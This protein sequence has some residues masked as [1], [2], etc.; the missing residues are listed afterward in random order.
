[1]TKCGKCG[2]QLGFLE[3]HDILLAYRTALNKGL[4][5]EYRGKKLC[6]SCQRELLDSKGIEYRRPFAGKLNAHGEIKGESCAS[7][8]KK[9]GFLRSPNNN[10]EPIYEAYPEYKGKRICD[11]CAIR[12]NAA[13]QE[14]VKNGTIK[15]CYEC[16]YCEEIIHDC[17]GVDDLGCYIDESYSTYKCRKFSLNPATNHLIAQ[18]CSSYIT[19]KEYQEKCISGEIEKAKKAL[20]KPI[21]WECGYCKAVNKGNF[22]FNCGSPRKKQK[23]LP[24]SVETTTEDSKQPSEI[25][26]KPMWYQEALKQHNVQL[27]GD[28]ESQ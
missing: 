15:S 20:E 7:C 13:I 22:C 6:Y 16:G 10:C 27:N 3:S 1:M 24:S 4:F 23:P 11:F 28:S 2:N 17:G 9:F 21:I 25:E 26:S 18:K 5:P 12:Y 8:G 19:Q 14:R